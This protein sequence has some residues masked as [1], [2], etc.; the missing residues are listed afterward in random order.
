MTTPPGVDPA[1]FLLA[2]DDASDVSIEV[3]ATEAAA[4]RFYA[5]PQGALPD[6]LRNRRVKRLR[7]VAVT[8]FES[9]PGG[10][11]DRLAAAM[12]RLPRR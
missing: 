4:Q 8:Y 6:D 7:N 5:S 11:R 1:A 2:E 10:T 9:T 3:F 12:A